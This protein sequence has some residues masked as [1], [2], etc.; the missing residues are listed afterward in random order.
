ME[1]AR[2]LAQ[3]DTSRREEGLRSKLKALRGLVLEM[4]RQVELDVYPIFKASLELACQSLEGPVACLHLADDEGSRLTLVETRG[5]DPVHLRAWER[6]AIDGDSPPA[7]AFRE[8]RALELRGDQA[9]AGLN[10]LATVP[11]YGFRVPLGTLSLM[12]PGQAAMPQDP[13]R[14]DFLTA[15]GGLVGLAIEHAGLVSELVDNL[16]QVMQLKSEAE[17]RSQE[18]EVLNQKLQDANRRLEELSIT[19]GLTGLFN[20]RHITELLVMEIKRSRRQGFPLCLVMAD[21]DHF[22]LI[23]DRLGHQVGDEALK[24]FARVL[25]NGVREV[26]SVGRYGGEE[27]LVILVDCDLEAGLGVADKLRAQVEERSQVEPFLELGGFTV[28]M[29]VAQ[30][31]PHMNANQ[32][33]AAADAAMYRAKQ[34]GRNRVMPAEQP[35]TPP[36]PR[37]G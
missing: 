6:L 22:K 20:H 30:L 4:T 14:V 34:A 5:R 7:R 13:D 27:F 3:K 9:P 11:V 12:W 21:L 1:K 28:S 29:G 32:L 19:D 10:G 18:L 36:P 23:N 2:V 35:P 37:R 16:N 26:D 15:V 8:E 17:A 33:I 24:L 25:K 31:K